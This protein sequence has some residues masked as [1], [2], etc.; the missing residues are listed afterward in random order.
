LY[1]FDLVYFLCTVYQNTGIS[2]FRVV[3][4]VKIAKARNVVWSSDMSYVAVISKHC[5]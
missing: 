3:A 2:I 4:T 1:I 5:K